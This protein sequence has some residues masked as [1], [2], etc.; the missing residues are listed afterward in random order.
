MEIFSR[1][2]ALLKSHFLSGLFVVIPLAVIAWIGAGLLGMLWQ[3]H[4]LIPDS[5]KPENFIPNEGLVHLVNLGITV[6]VA[7][8]LALGISFLGWSSKHIIGRKVLEW[9]GEVI[10]RIP[11][12]RSI[13]S[14]L[15]QLLRTIASGGGKQFSRVVYVEYPRK[16]TWVLAFVTGPA[17]GWDLKENYLNI[18]VPTTPNPTSG[19]H[20][21]VAESEVRESHMKV[22]D[23]F[24]TILSLGIAQS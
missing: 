7:A 23:A 14:A 2:S 10:Q 16:G 5:L 20:L 13:Y 17:K 24:K 15:D 18:Y 11:V 4:T 6:G 22:E 12:I 9:V 21:I 3:I 19:F 1:F 8:L